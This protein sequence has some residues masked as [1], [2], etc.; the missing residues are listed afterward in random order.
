M[1][2]C[3]FVTLAIIIFNSTNSI[4]GSHK[5]FSV[6]EKPGSKYFQLHSVSD[7]KH[8]TKNEFSYLVFL[9]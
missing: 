6:K 9:Q 8:S 2:S 5:V 1:K 7:N 4:P 3:I